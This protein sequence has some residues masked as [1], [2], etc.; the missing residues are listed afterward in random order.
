MQV[1]KTSHTVIENDI[2]YLN[3]IYNIRFLEWIQVL[4]VIRQ[5]SVSIAIQLH[6][7]DWVV[8]RHEIGYLTAAIEGE[9]L[10]IKTYVSKYEVDAR[11][12][13]VQ[14]INAQTGKSVLKSKTKCCMNDP[15]T[16]YP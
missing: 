12:I 15:K 16:K 14:I 13:E 3:Y 7:N 11:I 10:E 4:G 2:D 6:E 5:E 9:Q 8:M 1:F